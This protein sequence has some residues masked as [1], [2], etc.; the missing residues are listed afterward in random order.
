MNQYYQLES[1]EDFSVNG[2]RACVV[3]PADVKFPY[4]DEPYTS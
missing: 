1:G 4:N 2:T 3:L